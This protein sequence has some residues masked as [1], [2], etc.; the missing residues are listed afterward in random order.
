MTTN[1]LAAAAGEALTLMHNIEDD[2][3]EYKNSDTAM[4][5]THASEY[6]DRLNVAADRLAA[7]ISARVQP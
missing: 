6:A 4:I 1:D 7:A 5:F 2:L 3:L